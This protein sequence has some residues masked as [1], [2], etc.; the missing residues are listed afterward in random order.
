M[1]TFRTSEQGQFIKK[2]N[3]GTQ[4]HIKNIYA[5]IWYKFIKYV[6]KKQH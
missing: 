3:Y 5:Y 2:K 1:S 6:Y 4:R